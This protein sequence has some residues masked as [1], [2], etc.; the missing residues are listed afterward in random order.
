MSFEETKKWYNGY[1]LD[2]TAIYNPRSV[3]MSMTGKKYNNYWTQTETY[4]ALKVYISVNFEGLR[5]A[6]IHLIA[7]ETY[8]IDTSTF[9]NDMTT[10]H[11][12]DDVLTLLVHLGYLFYNFDTQEVRIPNYEIF[13]EFVSVIKISKWDKII[14]SI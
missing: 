6:I 7:G 2:G 13:K 8:K 5:D 14:K 12:L 11:N 4:K 1:N 9:S 3:V 10:F